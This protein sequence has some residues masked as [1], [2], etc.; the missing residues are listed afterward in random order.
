MLK[1]ICL[2]SFPFGRHPLYIEELARVIQPNEEFDGKDE[3]LAG[4]ILAKYNGRVIRAPEKEEQKKMKKNSR[5]K[6]LTEG[7][8]KGANDGFEQ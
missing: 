3:T 7:E 4:M 2:G 1:L 5:D 6:M 8:S